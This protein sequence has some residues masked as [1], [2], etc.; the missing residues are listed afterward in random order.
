MSVSRGTALDEEAESDGVPLGR[1]RAASFRSALAL[2]KKKLKAA[3]H[4]SIPLLA[5]I[6]LSA[7]DFPLCPTR[8]GIGVPCPGCGLTRATIAA[9]QFDLH[10]LW[11]F[12]PLAPILTPIVGWNFVK[13]ILLAHGWIKQ[14]W[15]DRI[16]RAPQ[17]F[18]WVLG[19]AMLVLWIGRLLGYF[20]GHPDEIDFS[21]GMFYRAVH[22]VYLLFSGQLL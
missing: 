19:I 7:I 13:P 11:H 10:G 12:H 18:W 9:L 1:R 8:L 16:P 21:T 4:A 14:S 5:I 3:F 20:G 15:V 2:D 22:G 6:A 17:A